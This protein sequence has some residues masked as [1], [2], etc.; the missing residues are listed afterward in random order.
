MHAVVNTSPDATSHRP[1]PPIAHTMSAVFVAGRCD[2]VH[3][4]PE[5]ESL[6]VFT[7]DE[8]TGAGEKVAE[9][10]TSKNP[11]W[12]AVDAAKSVLYCTGETVPQATVAAFSYTGTKVEQ[13]S[14]AAV[15]A[16]P[17]HLAVSGDTV[18]AACYCGRLAVIPRDAGDAAVLLA[19]KVEHVATQGSIPK[20]E[21]FSDRQ[22]ASHP[23]HVLPVRGTAVAVSDLGCD[24]V[25]M[26]DYESKKVLCAIALPEGAGPR[27]VLLHGGFLYGLNEL[28]NSLRVW[29]ASGREVVQERVPLLEDESQGKRTH[30]RGAS[31]MALSPCGRFMVVATRS[32]NELVVFAVDEK[33][34]VLSQVSRCASVASTPRHIVFRGGWLLLSAHLAPERVY[35]GEPQ[36][37]DVIAVFAFNK[38]SGELCHRSSIPCPYASCVAFLT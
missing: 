30:H 22:E 28:D 35:S 5:A 8:A 2:Y 6:Y 15:D 13:V 29:N 7:F 9:V 10:P 1:T 34:G 12:V 31:E 33:T 20:N 17:C 3:D 19:D 23:H 11:S 37:T 25:N 27:R 21:A 26:I 36:H 14:S 38:D 24:T 4:E 32:T 18:L 16:A